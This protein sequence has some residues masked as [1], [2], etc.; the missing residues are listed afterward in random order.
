MSLLTRLFGDKYN[1]RQPE[2]VVKKIPSDFEPSVDSI[3]LGWYWSEGK[4]A[5]QMARIAQKN[6]STHVYIVGASGSGKTKFIESLIRQ[7][8]ANGDGFGVIDPHG[9]LVEDIKTFLADLDD[10]AISEKVVLIDPTDPDYTVTF[11]LLENLPDVPLTEQVNEILSAFRKIWADSWGVRMEDLMRNSLMALGEAE[12]T[13]GDFSRFILR[14]DFRKV[15]LAKV[16]HPMVKDY[17]YR[18]DSMTDKGQISWIEPVM[19]KLNAF[20]AD[21]RIRQIFSSDTKSSFSFRDIMDNG[22]ILLVKLDKGRLKDS[23]DLLGSLI[24]AKVQMA[25][26]SRAGMPRHK[27]RPFY[28][29][30]DEFQNFATGSF[31]TIL[32]EARKYGL[33][34]VMAHQTLVQIPAELR[35]LILGNTGIQ[36]YFR[37]NHQDASLLAKEAFEF[38]T[39]APNE[40]WEHKVEDLQTLPPRFFFVKHKIEGGI[41]LLQTVEIE[42]ARESERIKAIK[43]A[44]GRKY[45]ISRRELAESVKAR[46]KSVDEEIQQRKAAERVVAEK[47]PPL[48]SQGDAETTGQRKRER[49]SRQETRQAAPKNTEKILATEELT[50]EERTFLDFVAQNPDMFVTRIYKELELSGYKGDKLKESLIEKGYLI[51]NETRDGI[52]GR[53]AKF[54]ALKGKSRLSVKESS[55]AGKGGDS[56]KY[57]QKTLKEQS[58]LFGWKAV[59]EERIPRT[60]ESVDVGLSKEDVR[61]AIEICAT[62]KT[63]QEIQ[64]IRKCLDAGYDYVV[65]VSSDEKR[66]SLIKTA[67]KKSFN[68]REREMLKFCLP[69]EVSRFLSRVSPEGVVS[70]KRVVSGHISK[71]K[72]LLDTTETSAFLGISKN[73]LYEWVLQNKVPHIKVGRLVKFRRDDLEEWL[74]KR[75]RDER[76][77]FT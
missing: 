32:S 12:L 75:T 23:A 24:M 8:I 67:A 39:F 62:T 38:S 11:N 54:L 69:S 29:Y 72:Q 46:Q 60:L 28:L 64:N 45:M 27:R 43:K 70:E 66:L 2:P 40:K 19:N 35:S 6:R 47:E 25:A 49:V 16:S 13:L 1:E 22:K 37:V 58:E 73:T 4:A 76:K 15:V 33:S 77:G 48:Q 57:L 14:R 65:S 34:L 17:F 71:E 63:E 21:E 18:F 56:H 7:D 50:E 30:I 3:D 10:S 36:V 20:L 61:I 42:S 53:L 51:Q 41:L 59:V 31:M 9:D 5:H 26:F 55:L 68:A 74:K 44:L 52:G